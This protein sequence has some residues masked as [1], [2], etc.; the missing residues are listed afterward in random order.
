[1]RWT[2]T[3]NNVN[4]DCLFLFYLQEKICEDSSSFDLKPGDLATGIEELNRL[5]EKIVQLSTQD[6]GNEDGDAAISESCFIPPIL[7]PCPLFSHTI[8]FPHS[9]TVFCEILC[10]PNTITSLK[11]GFLNHCCFLHQY[12]FLIK[13]MISQPIPFPFSKMFSRPIQSPY[14]FVFCLHL[15]V[16]FI[17]CEY[18]F[19]TIFE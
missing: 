6:L 5:A 17:V 10:L 15:S 2:C 11:Y 14:I 7:F 1:M 4:Y 16:K 9:S 3:W 19:I 12:C 13:I 8:L 18:L